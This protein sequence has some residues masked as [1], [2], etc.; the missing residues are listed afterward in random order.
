M[1][2]AMNSTQRME[3]YLSDYRVPYQVLS[4]EHTAT[5]LQTAHAAGIEA[6]R[7]AKAVLLQGDD[8]VL[9]AMIPADQNIRL[10]QLAE[11]LGRHVHLA[12]EATVRR[13]FTDCDPGAMPGLPVAWGVETVW[14]DALLAQPDIYLEAG[15]HERL[16]HVETR[17]FRNAFTDMAHC[18]F[19]GPKHPH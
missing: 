8:C 19:C 16:I 14:D 2:S 9:A 13:M 17:D 5:S 11:D 7:L 3:S 4:H 6:G 18:H 15:D 1:E 10:G 12:D